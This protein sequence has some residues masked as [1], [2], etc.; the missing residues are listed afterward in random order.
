MWT[1]IIRN[2]PFVITADHELKIKSP[3]R[4]VGINYSD[5]GIRRV[6]F[7]QCSVLPNNFR[8]KHRRE[9]NG[10]NLRSPFRFLGSNAAKCV[11][12]SKDFHIWMYGLDLWSV[13]RDAIF[14]TF[15]HFSQSD[16][17]CCPEVFKAQKCLKPNLDGSNGS[18]SSLVDICAE[19][20][21]SHFRARI[22]YAGL[23]STYLIHN[24]IFNHIIEKN[25]ALMALPVSI[26]L[27]PDLRRVRFREK[28]MQK[29]KQNSNLN[30]ENARG[31]W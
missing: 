10:L 3:Q 21:S 22:P 24:C 31:T 2:L 16:N 7:V 8:T 29:P 20:T 25:T 18:S 28:C 13:I 23:H 27:R 11:N 19:P 17:I 6:S 4:F 9:F 5:C 14:Q 26:R 15:C 1:V 12:D 30:I